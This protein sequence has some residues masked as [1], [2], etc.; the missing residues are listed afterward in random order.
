[1]SSETQQQQINTNECEKQKEEIIKE[2]IVKEEPDIKEEKKE[3][4][5]PI[6]G[7]NVSGRPWKEAYKK[8]SIK[9]NVAM[10]GISWE[11]KM[12]MKK[13][14]QMMRALDEEIRT[15]QAEEEAKR[16]EARKQAIIRKKENIAKNTI[17]Q[18]ITNKKKLRH[19]SGKQFR[20]LRTFHFDEIE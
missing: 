10:A 12:E 4:K 11:E 1:M 16:K 3:I 15:R 7:A 6:R 17:V 18:Q 5:K 2:I 20:Q 14:R 8:R 13:R 9:D 19:M